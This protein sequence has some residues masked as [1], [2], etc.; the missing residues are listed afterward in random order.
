MPTSIVCFS[1]QTAGPSSIPPS[2]LPPEPLAQALRMCTCNFL[3]YII[4]VLPNN[5]RYSSARSGTWDK[6]WPHG[7]FAGLRFQGEKLRLRNHL[8]LP[9][10]GEHNSAA[11]VATS[12]AAAALFVGRGMV[13]GMI[14][15]RSKMYT[16]YGH[17][18]C[19]TSCTKIPVR[20]SEMRLITIHMLEPY[21]FSFIGT[22]LT[23]RHVFSWVIFF[24][25]K[26]VHVLSLS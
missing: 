23:F 1:L 3:E 24:L 25:C 5:A 26:I 22:L 13:F 21:Q 18:S 15:W 19:W 20:C 16:N 7:H 14:Q 11:Y 2:P 4:L 17:W 12:R 9:R 6:K 8:V 10:C